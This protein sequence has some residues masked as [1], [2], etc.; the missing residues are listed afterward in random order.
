MIRTTLQRA[1]DAQ[2]LGISIELLPLSRLDEEFNIFVFYADLI[3]SDGKDLAQ[4]M[5]SAGQKYVFKIFLHLP[6]IFCAIT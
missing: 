5:P 3:G 4:F 2:D 6:H 1:K